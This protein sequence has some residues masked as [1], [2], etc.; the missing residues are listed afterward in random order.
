MDAKAL[1]RTL[2]D[3]SHRRGWGN[4]V[5]LAAAI[6]KGLEG[7]SGDQ[8]DEELLR[9]LI[10]ATYMARN[11]ESRKLIA[12]QILKSLP[13][14]LPHSDV[15]QID[16]VVVTALPIEAAKVLDRLADRREF[17]SSVGTVYEIGDLEGYGRTIRV[18]VVQSR[19]G[20]SNAALET[21]RALALFSPEV[22]MFV[23]I[24][25]GLKDDVVKG[26]VVVGDHIYEYS[27]GKDTAE[28]LQPRIREIQPS[29]RLLQRVLVESG[30]TE[31]YGETDKQHPMPPQVLVK[32]IAAGPRVVA[33][34]ESSTAK[35]I[36]Q[37]CGDSLAVEMEGFGF[38]QA[39]FAYKTTEAIVIRGI[40]DL[41]DDKSNADND[42]V[43][44]SLAAE[45]AAAFSM[46]VLGRYFQQKNSQG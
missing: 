9:S 35:W 32:P 30:G 24:A 18:A 12:R 36:K 11:G 39:A 21:E 33:S 14:R 22:S 7:R 40:S 46:H 25:G 45:R 15:E 2:V 41:V 27:G 38:L 16:C 8:V 13:E 20:N 19:A 42:S 28:G 37:Y 43:W 23:G 44:Q 5:L 6:V 4:E 3:L 29:Y 10:P 31:W 17:T 26:D 1:T 34:L